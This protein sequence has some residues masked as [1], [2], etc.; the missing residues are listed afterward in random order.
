MPLTA[1]PVPTVVFA[2][3]KAILDQTIADWMVANDG[4]APDLLG[5][6]TTDKFSW[7]TKAELLASTAKGLPLIDASLIG[8]NPGVGDQANLV[9]S[10]K[11]GVSVNNHKFPRMPYG[12]PYRTDA[13]IQLIVDWINGGCKP[14]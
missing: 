4:Q 14:D 1:S 12:G 7:S 6:H 11:T 13:E 5:R 10:L 9:I 2:E 3:V 8:K